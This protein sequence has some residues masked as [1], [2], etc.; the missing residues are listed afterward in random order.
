MTQ[1]HTAEQIQR[2]VRRRRIR[3]ALVGSV[4]VLAVAGT[5]VGLSVS[6]SDSTSRHSRPVAITPGSHVAERLDGAVQLVGK[7]TPLSKLDPA[8]TSAVADAD[9]ALAVA[10]LQHASL[11]PDE[12]GSPNV[13]TSSFSLFVALA[14]LE[15][16]ARG[17]TAARI[18]KALQASGLDM[19]TQDVGLAHLIANLSQQ[20]SDNKITLETANSLWQQQGFAIK[21]EFLST[22]ATYFHTGVWQTDFMGHTAQAVAAIDAWTSQNTH[23]KITKLFDSLDPST[24]LVLANALYFHAAWQ[25]P[26]DPSE[27]AP[28]EFTTSADKQVTANFMN[29]ESLGVKTGQ[30]EAAV[31]PYQ[32]DQ[33]EAVALMPTS[34][35]LATFI[36]GLTGSALTDMASAADKGQ[37]AQIELPKFT[38]TASMNMKPVLAALGMQFAGDFTGIADDPTLQVDQVRQ[39]VYLGVGEAGTTAAAATGVSMVGS[40][41]ELFPLTLRFDHPFLFLIRDKVSGAILFASEINNPSGS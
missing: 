31:L 41:A 2:V 7:T 13:S 15:N 22:L 17:S 32:G 35:S 4:A 34:G 33:F 8:A 27:T 29:G 9:T 6:G 12:N 24:L 28:E 16:G 37:T 20:A 19:T 40:S 26:F 11:L 18:A 38:T 36:A 23:G 10:L 5:T 1:W 14:M 21:P 30:Y 39:R 3:R 25:T